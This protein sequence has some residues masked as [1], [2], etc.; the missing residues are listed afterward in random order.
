MNFTNKKTLQKKLLDLNSQWFKD[1]TNSIPTLEV[2]EELL[3]NYLAVNPQDTE[4]RIKLAMVQYTV[5]LADDIAAMENLN[6]VLEYDPENIICLLSIA[7]IQSCLS[8]SLN[9]NIVKCLRNANPKTQQDK[10]LILYAESWHY[11]HFNIKKYENLLDESINAYSGYVWPHYF[12]AQAYYQKNDVA[13][14]CH[15]YKRAFD[16]IVH[17]CAEDEY[18]DIA[19]VNFFIDNEIKGTV[20]TDINFGRIKKIVDECRQLG[21]AS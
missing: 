19:D 15:Y 10:A 3:K 14:A 7:Y 1:P 12:R 16:N 13:M 18:F 4:M 6:M 8:G 9:L 17:V 20:L 2:M 21:Y 11:K 5:P